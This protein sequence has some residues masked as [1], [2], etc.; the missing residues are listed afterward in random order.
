MHVF[1]TNNYDTVFNSNY[2]IEPAYSRNWTKGLLGMKVFTIIFAFNE[3]PLALDYVLEFL[4]QDHYLNGMDCC[5]FQD[6]V[7]DP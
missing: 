7:V 3:L 5:P 2:I 4:M 1:L 6:L